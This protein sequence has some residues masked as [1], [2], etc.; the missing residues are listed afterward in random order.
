MWDHCSPQRKSTWHELSLTPQC[1]GIKELPCAAGDNR[2]APACQGPAGAEGNG[3]NGWGT[4]ADIAP[5]SV[6]PQLHPL[7]NIHKHKAL[8]KCFHR[9][10]LQLFLKFQ[11]QC[12]S[13]VFPA[14]LK[15][16]LKRQAWRGVWTSVLLQSC[17]GDAGEPVKDFRDTNLPLVIL[18]EVRSVPLQEKEGIIAWK[19][20]SAVP[21]W[22]ATAQIFLHAHK[23]HQVLAGMA[24]NSQVSALLVA[25]IKDLCGKINSYQY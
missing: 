4:A 2:L 16:G 7:H 23:I 21:W 5:C 20:I 11:Q 17:P 8:E 18:E 14:L 12:T 3:H 13:E 15:P 9:F 6:P 22:K 10:K 24:D 1:K 25:G 19:K